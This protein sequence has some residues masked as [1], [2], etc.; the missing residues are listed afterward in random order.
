MKVIN[1]KSAKGGLF[2]VEIIDGKFGE[3]TAQEEMCQKGETDIDAKG[4]L[5]VPGMVDIHVHSRDPGYTH[6]E[7]WH[8][9]A[10]A[11]YKGGVT[12]VCDM[13]NTMPN[14][15]DLA[16]IEL[17]HKIALASSLKHY[18]YLGVGV[19]NIDKLP[20]LLS[21]RSLPLC[22][23]KVYYGQS[24]GELMYDDLERL[25][26][27]LPKPFYGLLAFHS[28]D[29]CSID[30]NADLMQPE[31]CETNE[32]FRVHSKIRSSKAAHKSTQTIL[33]WAYKHDLPVHIAHLSTPYE[34]E[35]IEKAKARSQKVTS[36]VAPHHLLFSEE[37][38]E[39][40]GSHIKMNPPVRSLEEKEQLC[41]YF[42][43]GLIEAFAT[44]HAPHTLA[45]KSSKEYAKCPSGVPGVEWFAPLLLSLGKKYGLSLEAAIAMGSHVPYEL[46]GVRDAGKIEKGYQAD[47]VFLKEGEFTIV[48]DDVASKCGWTPF[49]GYKVDYRVESTFSGGAEVYGR[50]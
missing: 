36:E 15:M 27:A 14:T 20:A 29:Q 50:S 9:L 26:E 41:R 39:R 22:G 21:D 10:K 40:L 35:L 30:H 48:K 13:P 1:A 2:S 42:G 44:D 34:V 45:E 16:S 4:L 38:Y 24:T 32:S 37:D 49:H 7:D 31:S 11:A 47:F 8:T 17:K 43:E 25:Y 28:E 3:I 18:F 12:C 23:L 6:K 46:I 5:M 33:D 19:G